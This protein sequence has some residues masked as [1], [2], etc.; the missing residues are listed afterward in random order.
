MEDVDP[1][2]PIA[3][4]DKGAR[5]LYCSCP[6]EKAEE[7]AKAL[8]EARCCACVSIIPLVKSFYHWEGKLTA[9]GEALLVVKTVESKLTALADLLRRLHPYQVPEILV[10]PV[11]AGAPSYLC[12]LHAEVAIAGV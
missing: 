2:L 4:G 12:W 9:D 3:F 11:T 6:P 8:L 10:T 5:I 1:D 7:I